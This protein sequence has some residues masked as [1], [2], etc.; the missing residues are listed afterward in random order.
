MQKTTTKMKQWERR[1]SELGVNKTVA[2]RKKKKQTT[3]GK[4]KTRDSLSV[5]IFVC[6]F[7]NHKQQ[8]I[9]LL[10]HSSRYQ[11]NKW[12]NQ[13][14]FIIYLQK[15]GR[16]QKKNQFNQFHCIKKTVLKFDPENI[17]IKMK[18][19]GGKRNNQNSHK[20]PWVLVAV[21]AQFTEQQSPQDMRTS[22]QLVHEITLNRIFQVRPR[23]TTLWFKV[24]DSLAL[25]VQEP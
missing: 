16:S 22:L 18:N 19:K 11:D 13:N 14:E 4:R 9:P 6:C 21:L 2:L 12:L 10:L 8:N 20:W 24:E 7:P 3:S 23:Y 5:Y 17:D 25:N 1:K 15:Y